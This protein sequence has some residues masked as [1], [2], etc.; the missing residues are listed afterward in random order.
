MI[1]VSP[2]AFQG[3]I[4]HLAQPVHDHRFFNL[5]QNSVVDGSVVI[6]RFGAGRECAARHQNDPPATC[7]DR[8]AL[9]FVCADHVV[10]GQARVGRQMVGAGPG[11]HHGAGYV[12]CSF[13]APSDQFQRGWPVE[14]HAPLCGVHCFRDT[15]TEAP[16]M[17]PESDGAVPVHRRIQPRVVVSQ[18]IRDNMRSGIGDAVERAIRLRRK[19]PGCRGGKRFQRAVGGR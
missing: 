2:I 10:R 7:F 15:E 5:S 17:T 8:F 16:E 19:F 1:G 18:S 4:E 14:A 6:W 12:T 11:S 9:F 3:G 13:D